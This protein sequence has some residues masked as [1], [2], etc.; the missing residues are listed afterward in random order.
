[1]QKLFDD[2][3]HYDKRSVRAW[4]LLLHNSLKQKVQQFNCN[5]FKGKERIT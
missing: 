4:G 5:I 2:L 3:F 1:M